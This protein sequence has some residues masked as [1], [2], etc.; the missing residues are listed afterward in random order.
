MWWEW[1]FG[2]AALAGVGFGYYIFA[3]A[4]DDK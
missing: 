2:L 3:V 4:N 1:L